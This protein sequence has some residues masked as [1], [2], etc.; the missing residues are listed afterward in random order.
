[1]TVYP[2]R[3]KIE[4]VDLEIVLSFN[5]GHSFFM[6]YK[7]TCPHCDSTY[8]RSASLNGH[9]RV[10]HKSEFDTTSVQKVLS[11]KEAQS[12][13]YR[14][15]KD[16]ILEQRQKRLDKWHDYNLKQFKYRLK[17]TGLTVDKKGDQLTE[18]II[19]QEYNQSLETNLHSSRIK[20]PILDK[21]SYASGRDMVGC[22]D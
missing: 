20:K 8:S 21:G 10:K 18:I 19:N 22:W 7:I 14:N 16:K 1:M 2:C 11:R 15:N 5:R 6:K 17:N 3:N 13:Y 12:K 9:I 4:F